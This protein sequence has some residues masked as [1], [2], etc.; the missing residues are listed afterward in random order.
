MPVMKAKNGLGLLFDTAR[1]EPVTI[2]KS[3]RAGIVVVSVDEGNF[4]SYAPKSFSDSMG[5]FLQYKEG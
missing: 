3:G 5:N 2:E 4:K 1:S